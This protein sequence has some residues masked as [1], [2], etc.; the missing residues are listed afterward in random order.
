M[1]LSARSKLAIWRDEFVRARVNTLT[2][3][4]YFD[5]FTRAKNLRVNGWRAQEGPATNVRI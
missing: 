5:I 1:S 2:P 4:C 3:I